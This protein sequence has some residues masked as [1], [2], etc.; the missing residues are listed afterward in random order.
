[1]IT[2]RCYKRRE[3]LYVKTRQG[4]WI[5]ASASG[6]LLKLTA[7]WRQDY[8]DFRPHSSLGDLTPGEFRLAHL[9]GGNL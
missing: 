8:N 4:Q 9:E 7:T 3:L 1:M 5:H 6:Y 2:K